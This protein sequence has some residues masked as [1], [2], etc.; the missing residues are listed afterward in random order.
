MSNDTVEACVD[1]SLATV[2]LNSDHRRKES[3]LPFGSL[4]KSQPEEV[5]GNP[6]QG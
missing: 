1:D 5:Q 4:E 2:G 3:I 6:G